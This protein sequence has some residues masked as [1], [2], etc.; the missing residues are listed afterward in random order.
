ME[1]E[2][3]PLLASQDSVEQLQPRKPVHPFVKLLLGLWP[4][5]AS[6]RALRLWGKV[7][8]IVK[9]LEFCHFQSSMVSHLCL[10]PRQS[11]AGLMLSLTVPVI[12]REEENDNWNRWLNILHCVT[13]PMFIVLATKRE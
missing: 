10:L 5:G 2:Q 9:V 12:D 7:Y 11:P 6:F 3:T 4:F 1:D 8:E 13:A